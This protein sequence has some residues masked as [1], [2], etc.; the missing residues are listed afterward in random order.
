[1]LAIQE[2]ESYYG[3]FQALRDLTFEVQEGKIVALLGPNAAGKTTTLR[4]ISGEVQCRSGS[5]TYEGAELR[6]SNRKKS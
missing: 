2:V 6:G 3:E 4:T 5:V 1:M